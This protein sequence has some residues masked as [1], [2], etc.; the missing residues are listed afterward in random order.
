MIRFTRRVALVGSAASTAESCVMSARPVP[1][2]GSA[3]AL[4]AEFHRLAAALPSL[5]R[6]RDRVADL[7]TRLELEYGEAQDA[8]G[9]LIDRL[10]AAPL[11]TVADAE[12]LRGVAVALLLEGTDPARHEIFAK[13]EEAARRLASDA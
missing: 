8:A 7:M 9:Q 10:E 1:A 6:A 11:E 12:A 2:S 4:A 13:A 3:P 5:D